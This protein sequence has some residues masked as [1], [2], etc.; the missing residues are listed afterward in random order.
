LAPFP[1]EHFR[2]Y[3]IVR[4]E[5]EEIVM[6]IPCNFTVI[7][8]ESSDLYDLI[9]IYVYVTRLSQHYKKFH[10]VREPWFVSCHN[11]FE[12]FLQMCQIPILSAFVC[13]LN[14]WPSCFSFPLRTRDTRVPS[15]AESPL[16]WCYYWIN[17]RR[18]VRNIV[19]WCNIFNRYIHDLIDDPVR[20]GLKNTIHRTNFIS[21]SNLFP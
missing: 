20:P 9:C 2:I 11:F 12:W 3:I 19:H 13:I 4:I 6:G 21:S 18:K 5:N 1:L 16:E 14:I 15:Y 10:I 7:I 17:S 8:R